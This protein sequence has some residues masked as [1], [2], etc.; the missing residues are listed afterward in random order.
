MLWLFWIDSILGL[1]LIG[2]FPKCWC[3][4]IA[5]WNTIYLI[6]HLHLLKPPETTAP[7]SPTLPPV[8]PS[9]RALWFRWSLLTITWSLHPY[10]LPLLLWTWLLSNPATFKCQGTVFFPSTFLEI[11]IA[12][13]V[14]CIIYSA[15]VMISGSLIAMEPLECRAHLGFSFL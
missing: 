2:C 10:F 12:F 6:A 14:L 7:P 13:S 3:L 1:D 5:C 9:E 15:K 11:N 8:R 4:D